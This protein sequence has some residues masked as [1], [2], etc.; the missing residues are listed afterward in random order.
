MA[1]ARSLPLD[2]FSWFGQNMY[3]HTYI[4][5]NPFREIFHVYLVHISCCSTASIRYLLSRV[6]TLRMFCHSYWTNHPVSYRV[7][8]LPKIHKRGRPISKLIRT[9]LLVML[10]SRYPYS[11][12][13]FTLPAIPLWFFWLLMCS[14]GAIQRRWCALL[15]P[16]WADYMIQNP[17]MQ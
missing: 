1:N 12:P 5:K 13:R 16:E 17:M 7:T 6:I 15:I 9:H 14:R 10:L 11:T 3:I 8:N 2:L 4:T